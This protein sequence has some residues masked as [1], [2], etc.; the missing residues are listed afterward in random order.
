MTKQEFIAAWHHTD[1]CIKI[2]FLG[3]MCQVAFG[4]ILISVKVIKAI[5]KK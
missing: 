4:I 2:I 1:G 5:F 3:M